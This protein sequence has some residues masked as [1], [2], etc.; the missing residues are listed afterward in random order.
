M[1]FNVRNDLREPE[2]SSIKMWSSVVQHNWVLGSRGLNQLTGQV[3]HL[4]RLSDVTSAITGEHY[5]RDFPSVPG[6][7]QSA[8]PRIP[9]GHGWRGWIRRFADRHVMSSSSSDDVSQLARQS[10]AAKSGVDFKV[11]PKLRAAQ[12]ERALPDG[13]VLRRPVG[14]PQQQQRTLSAG[15]SDA[16]ASCGSGSR[17]TRSARRTSTTAPNSSRRGSRTTGAPPRG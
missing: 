8:E 13:D 14:H 4:Y 12:R 6:V 9:G 17:P 7:L 3:N 11:L 5:S 16:R 2:N 1:T 10:R 15:L